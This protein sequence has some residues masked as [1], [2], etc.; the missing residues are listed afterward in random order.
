[1]CTEAR[2]T[3][4]TWV[5]ARASRSTTSRLRPSLTLGTH[6]STGA[7]TT[8]SIIAKLLGY[9]TGAM[10]ALAV[11]KLPPQL[12]D[13]LLGKLVP[14]DPRVVIGPRLGEDAAVLDMGDRYLIATTDP[15]TFA[16]DKVGW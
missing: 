14:A 13:R 8:A 2:R 1:M 12:L 16:T 4:A 10:P 5:T 9:T 15:V 3:P 6:S 11:G 7:A